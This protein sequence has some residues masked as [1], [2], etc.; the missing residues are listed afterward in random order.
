MFTFSKAT[1]VD[2]DHDGARLCL[3]SCRPV[4]IYKEAVLVGYGRLEGGDV[5]HRL[6]K[7]DRV[8]G[9]GKLPAGGIVEALPVSDRLWLGKALSVALEFWRKKKW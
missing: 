3:G 7:G 6:R 2:P 4:D 5:L 1:A 9:A 8:L